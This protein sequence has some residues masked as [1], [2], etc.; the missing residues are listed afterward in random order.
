MLAARDQENLVH[1]HQAAAAAKPLNQ[2]IK[3]LPPRTP[4][5]KTAKPPLK[6]PLNDEN[7]PIAFGGGKKTLGKGNENAIFGDKQGGAAEGKTFVTPMGRCQARKLFL[8]HSGSTDIPSTG[9]RNRAPLGVKTTN[10]KAKAFQTPAPAS[11]GGGLGK[12][13]QK[14]VSI[15]KPKPKVSCPETTKLEDILADKEALDE[16]EIEYMPPKPKGRRPGLRPESCPNGHQICQI[17]QTITYP[18]S[19]LPFSMDLM[20]WQAGSSILPTSAPPAGFRIFNEKKSKRRRQTNTST[21]KEK[22][23]SN[24]Q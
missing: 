12:P 10:A 4:G 11:I 15:Q 6:L 22:Q 1:G 7:G 16:R 19:T 21:K 8:L 5:N 9:P 20:Y 3:Q 14:S 2:G 24:L 17:S 18:N 23:K 13:N